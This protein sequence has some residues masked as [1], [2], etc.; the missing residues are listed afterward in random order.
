[1]VMASLCLASADITRLLAGDS[2]CVQESDILASNLVGSLPG[3]CSHRL[4]GRSFSATDL[5]VGWLAYKHTSYPSV[6]SLC[7]LQHVQL[8]VLCA[9]SR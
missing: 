4:R 8:H 2:P 3:S 5:R 7:S 1:M 6:D 9:T